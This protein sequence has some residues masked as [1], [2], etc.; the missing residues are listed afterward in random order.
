MRF[1]LKSSLAGQALARSFSR[2]FR[3]AIIRSCKPASSCLHWR[4]C[5]STPRST[6]CMA[7]LTLAFDT[8]RSQ[9]L[10]F[11]RSALRHRALTLG[12][13]MLLFLV[14]IALLAPWISPYGPTATDLQHTLAQPS[15]AHLLGTDEYGR[16]VLS[17]L[18]WGTRIS[19]QVA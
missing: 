4:L 12:A 11:L 14:I 7:S 10:R 1:S 13:A 8:R 2:P 3:P 15:P 6:F 9:R 17:R 19:L 16:D 18:I 5:S